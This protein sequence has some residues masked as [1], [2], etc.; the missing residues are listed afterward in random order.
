MKNTSKILLFTLLAVMSGSA[1]AEVKPVT[2]EDIT[3]HVSTQNYYVQENAE[4]VYQAKKTIQLSRRNLL[5]KINLW[6][7]LGGFS[8]PLGLV[9][10]VAPFL[11]PNNWLRVKEDKVLAT[12]SV[13]GYRALWA[14]ELLTARGLLIQ[15]SLDE[16]LLEQLQENA[17]DFEP[18]YSVIQ[19]RENLGTA[20]SGSIQQ[21][22]VRR[23]ALNEE[24]NTLATIIKSNRSELAYI[25]GFP[26]NDEAVPTGVKYFEKSEAHPLRYEDY[27][28]RLLSASYE[29]KQHTSLIQA[30]NLI[31]KSRYFNFLGVSTMSRGAYGN[32]FDGL[33][34]QDGL[35]FGLG[36]SVQIVRSQKRILES[37]KRGIEETLRKNLKVLV[38]S[39]NLDLQLREDALQRIQAT[40]SQWQTLTDRMNL[41]AKIDVFD[42]I[43]AS[44][45]RIEAVS[46][47][48]SIETR[49]HLGSDRLKRL[50]YTDAYQVVEG[51]LPK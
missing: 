24:I 45:N 4:R 47:Y 30:A 27:E 42:L 16:R 5:P 51:S 39:Y 29:L 50:T 23:L 38:D 11:V 33:P 35:G 10:D 46:S 32:I 15:S 19:L 21:F 25:L 40:Q 28:E 22:E 26:G 20:P 48:Y 3:A 9:E 2:L 8:N 12:A 43:E 14:N 31:R 41:G 7:I 34:Q 13:H 36:P 18:L 6:R 17:K 44:R 1:L 49:L 37:Q